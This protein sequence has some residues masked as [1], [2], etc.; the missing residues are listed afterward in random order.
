MQLFVLIAFP[1]QAP[2]LAAMLAAAN[3]CWPGCYA[4][5]DYR[6]GGVIV[7]D[8]PEGKDAM[9]AAELV[10]KVLAPVQLAGSRWGENDG[11]RS[12]DV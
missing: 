8:E 4:G 2:Q 12:A 9:P 6:R 3:E 11:Y 5:L 1:V 7:S 10:D